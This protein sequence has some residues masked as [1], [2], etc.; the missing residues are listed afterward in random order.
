MTNGTPYLVSGVEILGN[1]YGAV[2]ASRCA[3]ILGIRVSNKGRRNRSTV[4][5]VAYYWNFL[6]EFWTIPLSSV[7]PDRT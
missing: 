4:V 5:A 7:K 6:T 3:T 1:T 2:S